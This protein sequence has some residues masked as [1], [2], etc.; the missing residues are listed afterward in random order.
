M[1]KLTFCGMMAMACMLNGVAVADD[2]CYDGM[3]PHHGSGMRMKGMGR[4]WMSGKVDSVDHKT[5][6]VKVKTDEGVL[7]VHFPPDS[8][9][10]LKEGETITVHLGFT[11][12]DMKDGGMMMDKPMQGGKPMK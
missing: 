7:S 6:W 5:G 12:G 10:D 4:H 9:K 3:G 11:K 2:D 1:N 8:V